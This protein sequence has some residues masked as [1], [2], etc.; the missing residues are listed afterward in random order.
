MTGVK[1]HVLLVA[2]AVAGSFWIIDA[3]LDT[4]F[5]DIM[6]RSL[7]MALFMS[8]GV[9]IYL[10]LR[11]GQ[12]EV[13]NHLTAIESSA[14]GIAIFSK[15]HEYLFVNDAY[16]RINGYQ[17]PSDMIGKTFRLIYDESQV[18]EMER[19]VF[20]ALEKSGRW[21]GELV[22]HK[23][24]GSWYTQDATVTRTEEQG[25][26]CV[27]RDVTER[28]RNEAA[29]HQSE[30]FLNS[31]FDSIHDPFCIFDRDF[32]IV[33]ANEAYAELKKKTVDEL[34]TRV[35][36]TVLYDKK[37]ICEDCVI[38]KSFSSGDPCAKEKMVKLVDGTTQWLEIYTYPIMDDQGQ[39]THVIEYT[40]DITD[41]RK[42]EEEK[43]RLIDRLEYLSKTDGLTGLLNRRA[44]NEQLVYEIERARRY[45]SG[46]SV[47]LCDLDSLKEINDTHGHLAG[48]TAIQ[49][50]AATLRNT[51][52]NVDI[53][54]RYGGDE[55]LVIAPQ[56]T[57]AGAASM[58]E[59][60]RAAAES[61]MIKLG[62][63]SFMKMSLSIGVACLG[64]L[65]EDADALISRVDAALYASK[66]SGRNRV[67]VAS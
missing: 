40:R 3:V 56:T 58:A 48:D 39:T 2:A 30:R 9:W 62:D 19:A 24:D 63:D 5:S 12:D 22:A 35:C 57:T 7:I 15:N 23:K 4:L 45:E 43:R 64:P 16:A 53:A 31:I 60:M 41:R 18:N 66:H 46:L 33:R 61:T 11:A 67:T 8:A 54:G 21:Q 1:R 17:S 50:V 27:M 38:E 26:V 14:D 49:L 42:S 36:H 28:K 32:R 20:P 65:P 25:C 29:I 37:T 52:R 47:I 59:K 51:L 55:F 13:K 10:R 34:I 6:V 44:L